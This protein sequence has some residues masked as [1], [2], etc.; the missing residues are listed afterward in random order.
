MGTPRVGS[1]FLLLALAAWAALAAHPAVAPTEAGPALGKG[2]LAG[3]VIDEAE[4]PVEGAAVA[5][6]VKGKEVLS[7]TTD[8]KGAFE[9][10]GMPTG[11]V[12]V[13]VR[14]KGYLTHGEAVVVAGKGTTRMRVPLQPGVTY[15]GRVAD[16][17]GAPVDGASV[18][19]VSLTKDE[20]K[21]PGDVD[22]V[23]QGF[24]RTGAD[25]SFHL[26]VSPG[27]GYALRVMHPHHVRKEVPG[28]PS[29][30]KAVKEDLAVALDDAAWVTGTVLDPA[31]KPVAGALV[32]GAPD[33]VWPID[34]STLFEEGARR[35]TVVFPSQSATTTDAKGRFTM[36]G[37]TDAK[38]EVTIDHVDFHF[39]KMPL[40]GLEAGKEHA[41]AEIRLE[42]A[43]GMVEGVVVDAKG[44]PVRD[45]W[46]AYEG[47]HGTVEATTDAGGRFRLAKLRSKDP[48]A[49]EVSAAGCADEHIEG[50]ALGAK[51]LKVTVKPAP[52][53]KALVTD[54]QGNLVK[55]LQVSVDRKDGSWRAARKWSLSW[56]SVE[57]S[58][59]GVDV[60]LPVKQAEVRLQA[61]G[62]KPKTIGPLDT[63]PG[64][65]V[66]GGTVVLE[67][68]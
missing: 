68:K 14:H 46:V 29:E 50:V 10:P 64:Q 18:Y 22:P 19:V 23:A 67:K 30:A 8:A 1:W 54:G 13:R 24:V 6:E 58:A 56:H 2:V 38:G 49:I 63:A 55:D 66:D 34:L 20:A 17:R 62:F 12:M 26:T 53:W 37:F 42:R 16:A 52:R 32:A 7:A 43:Q 3:V 25:G 28:L 47:E 33:F 65:V 15:G 60:G 40:E 36:G 4:K 51:S 31:G 5:V 27:K 61:F 44:K 59:A 41:L 48:V 39:V 11:D 57:Q 35:K 9:I 21:S 45:A